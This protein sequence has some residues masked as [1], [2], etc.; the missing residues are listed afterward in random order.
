MMNL[1][2]FIKSYIDD[3]YVG[4]KEFSW[5]LVPGDG[6]KRIF[7]RLSNNQNSF[8]VM[9]N[10]PIE[11]NSEKENISYLKIGEHLFRKGIPVACIYRYDLD[12]GWFIMED[13]GKMSLQKIVQNSKNRTEMYKRGL[14]SF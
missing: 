7:Y 12:H 2:E 1:K 8:I 10:S 6:S 14:L 4:N 9:A 3:S 13:L 11:S 5:E